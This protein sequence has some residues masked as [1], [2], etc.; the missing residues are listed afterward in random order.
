MKNN[1]YS[2]RQLNN[3]YWIIK[4]YRKKCYCA[5]ASEILEHGV[6]AHHEAGQLHISVYLPQIE[7]CLKLLSFIISNIGD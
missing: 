5:L 7:S 2:S 1:D 6:S 4:I 3:F